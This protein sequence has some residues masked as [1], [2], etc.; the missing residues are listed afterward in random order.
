MPTYTANLG[1]KVPT[2]GSDTNDWGDYLNSD[3]SYLDN[4]FE[5]SGTS[6]SLLIG[7][8]P[9]NT[10]TATGQTT[11]TLDQIRLKDDRIIEFGTGVDYWL[12]YNST[13]TQ[14][15]LNSTDVNG[16][17]GNGIVFYVGDGTDDVF[18]TG[19]VDAD[20]LLTKV[21]RVQDADKSAYVQFCA[22]NVVSASYA[23][24]YPATSAS[25]T[26]GQALRVASIDT[27]GDPDEVTLE[28]YTHD[29]TGSP[30]AN[31]KIWIGDASGDAQEFAL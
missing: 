13:G 7:N 20:H 9:I 27:S 18:F 12:N 30:L 5:V 4:I 2:V 31:T 21:L 29:T 15:E 11:F 23:L 3:L 25:T 10:P 26:A 16:S 17:G 6:I 24:C 22:P 1:L 28:W 8:Q 14:F 19:A